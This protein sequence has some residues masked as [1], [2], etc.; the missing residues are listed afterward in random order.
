MAVGDSVCDRDCDRVCLVTLCIV[1]MVED[2]GIGFICLGSSEVF[3]FGSVNVLGVIC[4][5]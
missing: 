3:R 2:L 1:S 5:F 4:G